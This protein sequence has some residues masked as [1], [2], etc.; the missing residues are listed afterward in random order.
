MINV[1]LK[2]LH[3][4]RSMKIKLV[5]IKLQKLQKKNKSIKSYANTFDYKQTSTGVRKNEF[6]KQQSYWKYP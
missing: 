4:D 6:E 5:K 1:Y 3:S 2:K